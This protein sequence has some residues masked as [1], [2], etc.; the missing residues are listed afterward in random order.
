MGA[1]EGGNMAIPLP[2]FKEIIELVNK[3]AAIKAQKEIMKLQEYTLEL[4]EEN[5]SL[6]RRL[7][8]LEL[9]LKQSGQ[10]I[11]RHHFYYIE[12]DEIPHYPRC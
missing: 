12:G 4:R 5:I 11:F 10:M 6:K 1:K 8:E 7:S 2:S 9:Q 3:G